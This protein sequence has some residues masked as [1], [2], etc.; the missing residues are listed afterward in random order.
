[1]ITVAVQTAVI[2]PDSQIGQGEIV[3]LIAYI[4]HRRSPIFVF[5]GFSPVRAQFGI[6]DARTVPVFTRQSKEWFIDE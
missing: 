5:M 3:R 6:D 4:Q 2:I 1:M